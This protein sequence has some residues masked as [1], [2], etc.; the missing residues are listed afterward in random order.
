[1]SNDGNLYVNDGA[2]Y[3][4]QDFQA[5]EPAQQAL[6]RQEQLENFAA[7]YPIIQD[8]IQWFEAAIDSLDS[9]SAMIEYAQLRGLPKETV[10]EAS[11]I[12]RTLLEDKFS[13]FKDLK[14][15]D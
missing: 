6:E 8:V 12:A 14:A 4:D 11:D 15:N 10:G 2:T 1:M 3:Q 13:Q 7:S 9:R 5:K